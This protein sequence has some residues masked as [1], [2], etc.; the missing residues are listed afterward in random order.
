MINNK[1]SCKIV[2]QKVNLDYAHLWLHNHFQ[3]SEGG[4]ASCDSHRQRQF[5]VVFS[6]RRS[7][8]QLGKQLNESLAHTEYAQMIPESPKCGIKRYGDVTQC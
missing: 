2:N 8:K 6:G 3:L 1:L 7:G 5:P 4:A